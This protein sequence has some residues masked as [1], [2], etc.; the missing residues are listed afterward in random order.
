M[1]Q[2]GTGKITTV[3]MLKQEDDMH[4]KWKASSQ[5]HLDDEDIK[6]NPKNTQFLF[7]QPCRIAVWLAKSPVFNFMKGQSLVVDEHKPIKKWKQWPREVKRAS[8]P[9]GKDEGECLV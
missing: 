4:S 6:E 2:Y 3:H 8:G 9:D 7:L 5:L 1:I